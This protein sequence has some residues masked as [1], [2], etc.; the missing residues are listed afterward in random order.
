MRLVRADS[1]MMVVVRA[2]AEE[3]RLRD[4][5]TPSFEES[6]FSTIK[7]SVKLGLVTPPDV[8]G[9]ATGTVPWSPELVVELTVLA[10]VFAP[11]GNPRP[12][13]EP[14]S[15]EAIARPRTNQ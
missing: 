2:P 13:S 8:A 15:D 11:L 9:M 10:L 12:K 14:L 3:D 6:S 7:W 1:V 5:D 4:E